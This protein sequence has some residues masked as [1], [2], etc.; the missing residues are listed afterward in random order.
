MHVVT[1]HPNFTA[2]PGTCSLRTYDLVGRRVDRDHRLTV[3]TGVYGK[4]DLR[5]ARKSAL[6]R[7]S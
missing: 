7:D 2:S 5:S 1:V 6:S 3:V 4:S